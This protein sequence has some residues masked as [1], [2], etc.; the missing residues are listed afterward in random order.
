MEMARARG[1]GEEI[2]RWL[3]DGEGR[4]FRGFWGG[5]GGDVGYRGSDYGG[6]GMVGEEEEEEVMLLDD[7][8]PGELWVDERRGGYVLR[9]E[10]GYNVDDDADDADDADDGGMRDGYA[11][12]RRRDGGF[13]EI[14]RL[15]ELAR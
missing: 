13:E 4:G 10:E 15:L 11:G 5:G 9:E 14:D 6:G 8:I 7:D 1:R 12:T 2:V 3:G